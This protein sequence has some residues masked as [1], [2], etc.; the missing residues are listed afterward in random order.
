MCGTRLRLHFSKIG[1]N[2][3]KKTF[4][5]NYLNP[6]IIRALFGLPFAIVKQ[7]TVKSLAGHEIGFFY[8][9]LPL[10]Y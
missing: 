9:F 4:W 3:E 10:H 1:L 7:I 5:E 2:V 8:Q 6:E